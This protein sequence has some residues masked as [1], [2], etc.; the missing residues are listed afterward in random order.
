VL[1]YLRHLKALLS[2]PEHTVESINVAA[3]PPSAAI[4]AVPTEPQQV[5]EQPPVEAPPETAYVAQPPVDVRPA[6]PS[7]GDDFVGRRITF[8]SITQALDDATGD[9][10]CT[11]FEGYPAQSLMSNR[12]RALMF[13]LIRMLDASDVAEIGTYHAGGA[14]VMARALW[15]NGSGLLRTTEPYNAEKAAAIIAT[16]PGEIRKLVE[17]HALNSMEFLIRLHHQGVALD[18][19]LIDGDHDYEPVL[20]DLQMSARLLRPNGIVLLNDAVQSGPFQAARTFLAANPAWRE[21][22][23]AISSYD[24]DSPFVGQWTSQRDTNFLVLQAPDHWSVGALP[25]SWGQT[26]AGAPVIDEIVIDAVPQRTRGTLHYR[27]I[28]RVFGEG[29]PQEAKLVGS[30]PIELQ[31]TASTLVHRL[32]T[33]L[34]FNVLANPDTTKFTSEIELCWRADQGSPP[35]A[36]ASPPRPRDASL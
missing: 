24:E 33:P 11:Y 30:L 23:T 35:L 7:L 3:D 5:A 10:L 13:L 26:A 16:W 15:A 18:F 28:L 29:I 31:G 6:G 36:L 8:E 34:S 21:I 22:G 1:R 4:E 17:F 27:A 19:V 9:E 25:R 14:E 12:S 20:F 32:E 2:G